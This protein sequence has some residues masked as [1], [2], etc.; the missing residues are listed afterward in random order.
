MTENISPRLLRLYHPAI[1]WVIRV[2]IGL[3]FIVSGFVKGVD[4]W[5]SCIKIGEYFEVWGWGI[6]SPLITC[7]A[8]MLAGTEF[9][10]G[11]LLLLGCYKRVAV[12]VLS[13]MMAF[14]LPLT[15]YIA[16]ASPVDDCGCFGDFMVLSNTSTFIKNLFITAGL[17]YLIVFNRRVDGLFVPYVQWIVGGLI[18][19]YILVIELIGYNI[20]PLLD[21]RRFSPGTDLVASTESIEETVFDYIY[22]KNGH[23]ERFRI[24]NL[25][26]STWAFVD[27]EIVSGGESVDDGFVILD[28]EGDDISSDIIDSETEQFIVTVPDIGKVDL[29]CTYIINELNAYIIERGGSLV[30]LISADSIGMAWW[31]DVS[32]ADYPVYGADPK[33]LKELAR[34]NGALV[35][36]DRGVVKWKRAL[37]SISYTFMTEA[38][39]RELIRSLNPETSYVHKIITVPFVSILLVLLVLDRSGKLL[40]WHLSRRNIRNKSMK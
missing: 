25:P 5:G 33:L 34:G 1:V 38:P 40:K 6:P 30:A 15:L 37:S 31:K 22:E 28:E 17:L 4:P 21:F 3:T 7:A 29:S 11:F 14:M 19:G 13:L 20:Q 2:L 10:F 18:T 24:N 9:V 39:A 32:M 23:R 8:F 12:W 35:Y 26:D 16:V 27:R 36:L